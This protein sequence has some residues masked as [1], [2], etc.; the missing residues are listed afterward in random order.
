[1]AEVGR[2]PPRTRAARKSAAST[3]AAEQPKPPTNGG[4]P[5]DPLPLA[6]VQPIQDRETRKHLKDLLQNLHRM[7][8]QLRAARERLQS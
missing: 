6:S 8:K 4:G 5:S 1:V 3:P 7:K 2:Q